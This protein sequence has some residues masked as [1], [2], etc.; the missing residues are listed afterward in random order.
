MEIREIL[1]NL[2]TIAVV[3]IS[4]KKERP[5]YQV[6]SYLLEKE[7]VI[8]PVNPK[9]SEWRGIRAYP[10]LAEIKE[11]IDIVDIFRRSE[12]VPAIVDDAIRKNAKT[13]WMQLGV[14]NE[15]AAEKA[16]KAGLSVVIDRCIK[17]EHQ[18]LE[19]H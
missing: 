4:D 9:L 18:N 10:S 3:G 6:A 2:K 8:I 11:S 14:V 19:K 15:E 12:F 1:R 16:R 13:I 5:S 17:I 7:Y